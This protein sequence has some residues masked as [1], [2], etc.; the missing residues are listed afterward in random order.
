M[1]NVSISEL[2]L[3]IAA[4]TVAAG[5]ATTL[6][7]NV[8]HISN[9]VSERGGD[10]A[11]KIQTEVQ[12]INDPGSAGSIYNSSTG[13]VTLLVKNTGDR[14]LDA[15][16]GQF[17]VLIDGQYRVPANVTVLGS[18]STWRPGEVVAV[19]ITDS[20]SAGPHR[21]VVYVDD[22]KEVLRFRT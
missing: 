8:M 21:A 2:V 16:P 15:R 5:V 20:L 9:A 12:I 4:L 13:N 22:D 10:V 1:A 6:T 19:T 3:F 18:A 7:T 17:D 11:N 14:P